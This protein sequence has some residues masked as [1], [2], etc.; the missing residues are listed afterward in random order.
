MFHRVQLPLKKILID[1]FKN[2][3]ENIDI[4]DSFKHQINDDKDALKFEDFI[5][6]VIKN[7]RGNLS[8][9]WNMFIIL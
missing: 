8:P 2:I 6:E 9:F 5:K 3:L 7:R 1:I 4:T